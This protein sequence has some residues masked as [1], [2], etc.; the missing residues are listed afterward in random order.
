[1]KWHCT[2][3]WK[4]F[5]EETVGRRDEG[6]GPTEAWG[7]VSVHHDWVEV[8]PDCGEHADE[9]RLPSC[10]NCGEELTKVEF[11]IEGTICQKCAEEEL[12][13][14]CKADMAEAKKNPLLAVA[15]AKIAAGTF[16]LSTE[17]MAALRAWCFPQIERFG[18]DGFTCDACEGR[19]SCEYIYDPYNTGG[20]CAPSK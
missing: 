8:C 3:C 17:E 1:V 20:D 6:I 18:H 15:R 14:A 5:D 13:E 10:D 2:S 11:D 16:L 9:G 4:E 12:D 7:S 19:E